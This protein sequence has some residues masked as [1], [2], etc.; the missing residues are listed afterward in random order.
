MEQFALIGR[1]VKGISG[2]YLILRKDLMTALTK[3]LICPDTDIK[4]IMNF[5]PKVLLTV[6]SAK[7]M[8]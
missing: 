8:F 3:I 2:K 5:S 7:L 1:I 4:T 6:S